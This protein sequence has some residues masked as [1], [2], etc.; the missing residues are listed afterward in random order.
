LPPDFSVGW[1]VEVIEERVIGE[2]RTS[3][4]MVLWEG[5][6]KDPGNDRRI[7]IQTHFALMRQLGNL[8]VYGMIKYEDVLANSYE[9][10][11]GYIWVPAVVNFGRIGNFYRGPDEWNRAK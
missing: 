11:F 6:W 10:S 2:D 7:S 3:R 5:S 9:S 4:F 8:V 1:P